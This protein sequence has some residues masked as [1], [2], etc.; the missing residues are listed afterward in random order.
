[1]DPVKNAAENLESKPAADNMPNATGK[2]E[3][4]ETEGAKSGTP[5]LSTAAK[6][7]S[8]A[9]NIEPGTEGAQHTGLMEPHSPAAN[10]LP[11][12]GASGIIKPADQIRTNE[13]NVL[14]TNIPMSSNPI[15]DETTPLPPYQNPNDVKFKVKYSAGFK[16]QKT[17][18]EG[19]IQIISK[20]SAAHFTKIGIGSV[21][22]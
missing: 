19:S 21:I 12:A 10:S 4:V 16:G 18:P 15:V 7:N 6:T 3:P 14:E 20:E 1:M 11:N 5:T 9:E 8:P 2:S 22:K 13:P 17:M